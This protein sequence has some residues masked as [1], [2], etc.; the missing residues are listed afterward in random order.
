[1]REMAT[2]QQG[3]VVRVKSSYDPFYIPFREGRPLEVVVERATPDSVYVR[4]PIG[5]EEDL[6][7]S[8]TVPYSPDALELVNRQSDCP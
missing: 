2:F 6:E 7:S 3:D 1:M 5:A 8:V 4:V